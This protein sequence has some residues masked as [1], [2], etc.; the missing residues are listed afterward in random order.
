MSSRVPV[1]LPEGARLRQ[2]VDGSVVVVPANQDEPVAAVNAP[3]AR[4]ARGKD[5]PTSYR[6]DGDTLVQ[7]VDFAAATALPVV[8]DP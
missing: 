2:A 1:S 3:W 5:V 8:A 7:R 6:L 4:D